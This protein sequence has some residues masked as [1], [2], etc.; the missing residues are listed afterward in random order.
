MVLARGAAGF[1]VVLGVAVE[2]DGVGLVTGLGAAV[3][4]GAGA[5]QVEAELDAVAVETAAPI[6]GSG[7]AEL[8]VL[9]ANTLARKGAVE[10]PQ[11]SFTCAQALFS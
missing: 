5:A 7:G 4:D 2:A 11:P 9:D 1:E 8:V 10:L 6:D 3:A